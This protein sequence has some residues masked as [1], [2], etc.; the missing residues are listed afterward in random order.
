[1]NADGWVPEKE[2]TIV[3]VGVPHPRLTRRWSM[4]ITIAKFVLLAIAI[5]GVL[6]EIVG[7]FH[8]HEPP[9]L[10]NLYR[11]LLYVILAGMSWI[12]GVLRGVE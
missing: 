9:T 5:I 10:N 11:V 2:E 7:T 6:M 3:E 4:E 12:L 8:S 1:M